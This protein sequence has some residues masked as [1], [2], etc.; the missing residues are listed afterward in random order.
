VIFTA[1]FGE[2]L[3]LGFTFYQTGCGSIVVVLS[4]SIQEVVSS[5][6]AC[7]GRVKPK[8]FKIGS[9]LLLRQERKNDGSFGYDLKNRGIVSQ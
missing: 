8:P 7:T 2:D 1:R 6:P 3:R 5:S 4:F 9:E